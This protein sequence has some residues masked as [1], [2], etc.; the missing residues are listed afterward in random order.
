[1]TKTAIAP[2]ASPTAEKAPLITA[3]KLVKVYDAGKVQALRE[4]SL[5]VSEGEFL[6]I[7][8]SSGSGKSTLLHVL[9]TL[10]SPDS[11]SLKFEGV[12]LRDIPNLA[13]FRASNLG[14]VFQ[15]HFLLPHLSLEEN[16]A[17]P[18]EGVGIGRRERLERAK[19]ALAKVGLAHRATHLPNYVS[20]GER[21]R[22]AIARAIVNNPT[23]IYA[24]EP[25]GNLDSKTERE[26]LELFQKIRDDIGATFIVVT[27]DAAVAERAERVLWMKDGRLF[28]QE[29]NDDAEIESKDNE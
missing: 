24:D 22:A 6:T 19:E 13:K 9:G 26:L 7:M 4:V 14:F 16:V 28:D 21:Q 12:E 2:E 29:P 1:M 18:L 25:T 5:T 15:M 23:L 27:H 10:D 17:L 20:G 3:D 8:G 11:G